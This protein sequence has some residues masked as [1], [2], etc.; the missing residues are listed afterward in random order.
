MLKH[1]NRPSRLPGQQI[2]LRRPSAP[3]LLEHIDQLET[4]VAA[5]N[6]RLSHPTSALREHLARLMTPT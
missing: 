6:G 3:Q 2:R 5:A 1:Q 4:E